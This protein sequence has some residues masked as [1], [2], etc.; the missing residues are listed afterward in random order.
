MKKDFVIKAF[1]QSIFF[2]F[3]LIVTSYVLLTAYGYQIDLINRDLIKTTIIDIQTPLN[4]VEIYF[5]D[6][7]VSYKAPF[8]IK[9]VSFE[10]HNLLIRKEG[11][12][13]IKENIIPEE[14]IVYQVTDSLLIPI[15]IL[16][17]QSI[18]LSDVS[19]DNIFH[20]SDYVVLVSIQANKIYVARSGDPQI[21]IYNLQLPEDSE[22]YFINKNEIVFSNDIKY[23]IFN[24]K[25]NSVRD[26]GI[27]TDNDLAIGIED[28]IDEL[29]DHEILE[30]M[31]SSDNL[32]Y[33][34]ST[35]NNEIY[36]Y[37]FLDETAEFLGRFSSAIENL[38]WFNNTSHILFSIKDSNY[39]CDKKFMNCFKLNIDKDVT[40]IFP[41]SD[42]TIITVSGNDLQEV[43]LIDFLD[44]S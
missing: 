27:L 25:T 41:L 16:N 32:E 30:G 1:F 37:N 42:N 19:F 10:K 3:F 28:E 12:H 40:D 21:D 17:Y 20:N 8:Q 26:E 23:L 7:L 24:L 14:N 33:L 35:N 2:I 18:L 6:E 15:D 38:N 9:N 22:G 31:I 39:I 44:K 36:I 4:D 13:E 5:D 29:I 43:T 34:C 11:Y